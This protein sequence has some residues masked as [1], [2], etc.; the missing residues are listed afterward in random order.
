MTRASDMFDRFLNTFAAWALALLWILPLAY[1]V[2]TAIHPSAYEAN[3]DLFAPL[4]TENFVKAW[5][6]APFHRYF[7]NTFILV[8]MILAWVNS[9]CAPW[10]PSPSHGSNFPAGTYC[11]L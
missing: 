3:F 11:L 4:T 6:A 8:T 7:L 5:E 2:W 1:A 10:P 9:S